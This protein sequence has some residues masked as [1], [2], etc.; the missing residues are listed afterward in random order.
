MDAVEVAFQTYAQLRRVKVK[1]AVAIS[2]FHNMHIDVCNTACSNRVNF[3]LLPFHMRQRHDGGLETITSGLKEVN[4][5]V[6]RNPPCSVGLLVDNGLG[7]ATA[8]PPENC[9]QH[10]YVLFFGGPDDRE[11]LMLARRMLQHGGIKLT[12]I[13]FVIQGL[14]HHRLCS[15]RRISN[16]TLMSQLQTQSPAG[17]GWGALTWL[18]REIV[19]FFKAPWIKT[20][21]RVKYMHNNGNHE[22]GQVDEADGNKAQ[23]KE[24]IRVFVDNAVSKSERHLD[25]QALVPILEAATKAQ[26]QEDGNRGDKD[27]PLSTSQGLQTTN[28]ALQSGIASRNLVLRVVETENLE[29]SVLDVVNSAQRN[30]LVIIGQHLHQNSP[31]MKPWA[32]TSVEDHGLGPLGNFLVTKK[33][34]QMQVSLLVVKQHSPSQDMVSK[35]SSPAPCHR[36]C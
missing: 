14:G 7:C 23:S 12:V 20:K 35:S 34:L 32:F 27:V 5:E 11:A 15:I 18:A 25:M 17:R 13:Q 21:K 33:H 24:E 26:K 3:L 1:T 10:I 6:L 9:S 2:A 19:D 16:S 36:R 30:G 22:A 31:A 4:L 8:S 28:S 29:E